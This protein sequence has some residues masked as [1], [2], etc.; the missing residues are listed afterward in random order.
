MTF[1]DPCVKDHPNI[2]LSE[3]DRIRYGIIDSHPDCF[4]LLK[5]EGIT[6]MHNGRDFT[7]EYF[8]NVADAKRRWRQI[9][10]KSRRKS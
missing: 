7:F 10:R 2:P 6:F 9:H 8:T 4:P 1:D 5:R 3:A